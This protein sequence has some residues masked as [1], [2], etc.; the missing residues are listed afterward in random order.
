MNTFCRYIDFGIVAEFAYKRHT[1]V[2]LN[3][4]YPSVTGMVL[5]IM[6]QS[7][8]GMMGHVV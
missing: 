1:I 2:V 6:Q 4:V 3:V 7:Y 5:Q 8:S